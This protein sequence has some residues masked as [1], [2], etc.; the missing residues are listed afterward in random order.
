MDGSTHFD[1]VWSDGTGWKQCYTAAVKKFGKE[2]VIV[3]TGDRYLVGD[4]S[5]EGITAFI[6]SATDEDVYRT[7]SGVIDEIKK[8]IPVMT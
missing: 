8:L 7:P 6:K 3:Y 1:F 2:N 4:L 5:K